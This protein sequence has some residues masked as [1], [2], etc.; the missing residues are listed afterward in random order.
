MPYGN[1]ELHVGHI[2]AVFIHA[3]VFARFLRDRIGPENVLFISGTDCFGS[4]IAEHFRQRTSS[5]TFDGTIED[6]AR[7]NH[8]KQKKALEVFNISVDLFGA[9]GLNHTGLTHEAFTSH[10]IRRLHE[11]GHLVKQSTSQFFDPVYRS[12]LNGRQ[13]LGKCPILD[14]GSDKAYADECALGHQYMPTQLLEPRS[15]LS[16]EQP[17]MREVTN[18]Y[19]TLPDFSSQLRIWLDRA[20]A[21]PG[22]RAFALKS[23]EE[24]MEPPALYLKKEHLDCLSGITQQLPVFQLN[25]ADHRSSVKLIF[26]SLSDREAAFLMLNDH[27]IRCRSGKTLVPF[28]ITGNIDWGVKAPDLEDLSD[29]T[30]WVWP[31]S[32]WAPI[33]FTQA[34]LES[35]NGNQESWRDWWC[36]ASSKVYQFLG[37]DNVYFYGPA[38]MAMFMGYN[39]KE[40]SP[41]S[42]DGHLQLPELIVNNHLLFLNRKA[43]SSSDF[44]PPTALALL[45][46]YTV[47][48][49][50][51][52]FLSLGLG[53]R[54]VSFQPKAFDPDASENENDPVLKEGNLLTN[55]LN[56]FAR[57]CFYAA[58]KY[59]NGKIPFGDISAEVLSEARDTIC[60]YERLMH[61]HSFHQVMSLLDTYIRGINKY[62]SRQLRKA[63]ER[64]DADLRKNTLVDGFHMLRTAAALIHP[65]APEGSEKIREYLNLD[66]AFWSWQTIFE[67]VY[68]FMN[69]RDT[70]RLNYLEPK[71]DFFKKH[72]SQL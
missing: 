49:L 40:P 52:H 33:S 70:H 63:E 16:G 9:S 68:A 25:Q 11:N 19:F 66:G 37:I 65:I 42:P 12:F 67:P 61:A 47:E 18:W 51:S 28:R 46:Y 50:R 45:N 7:E 29:L 24:F 22:C 5:G 53:L 58:Q 6:F 27:K 8:E 3:D 38:E 17:E 62:A 64:A 69:H 55:V 20:A 60:A 41:E 32:L 59:F 36:S 2:G 56:R 21:Q 26:S 44:K 72:P 39:G 1:K 4:P 34:Y 10:F 43:G 35:K 31:E 30:V 57:T 14:C 71:T 48:Q 15:T 13:V 23:I 54:S